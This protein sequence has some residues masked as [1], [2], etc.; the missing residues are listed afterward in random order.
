L[1]AEL[2]QVEA[3]GR[4]HSPYLLVRKVAGRNTRRE[5]LAKTQQ[6]LAVAAG[7]KVV[8]MGKS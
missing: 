5:A 7:R 3:V 1:D 6:H 4:E 8:A 2:H